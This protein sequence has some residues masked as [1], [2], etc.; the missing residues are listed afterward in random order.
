[1][2]DFGDYYSTPGTRNDFWDDMAAVER[3][4]R[5]EHERHLAEVAADRRERMRDVPGGS[6]VNRKKEAA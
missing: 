1:M 4:E 2:S 6:A 3:D 5:A